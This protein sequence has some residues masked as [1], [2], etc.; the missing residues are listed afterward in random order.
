MKEK[1]PKTGVIE[2]LFKRLDKYA[3]IEGQDIYW[4][5]IPTDDPDVD[6]IGGAFDRDGYGYGYSE[7]FNTRYNR[8]LISVVSQ[9]TEAIKKLNDGEEVEPLGKIENP[10]QP[11]KKNIIITE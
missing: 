6:L 5:V 10:E 11:K 4:Y 1:T 8:A 9:L 7:T 3:Q 2:K